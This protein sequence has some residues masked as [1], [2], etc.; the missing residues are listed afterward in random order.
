MVENWRQ[1]EISLSEM[2]VCFVVAGKCGGVT[3]DMGR[4]RAV[5][6]NRRLR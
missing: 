2:K 4:R 5:K 6:G 3:A 1:M